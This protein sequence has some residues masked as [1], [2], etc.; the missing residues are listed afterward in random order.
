LDHE[1]EIEKERVRRRM[2]DIESERCRLE[3]AI[4]REREQK[5]RFD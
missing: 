2:E 5:E 4:E 3:E 1:R